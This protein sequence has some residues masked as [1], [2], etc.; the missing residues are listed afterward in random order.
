MRRGQFATPY[1]QVI[2]PQERSR[3]HEFPT[4]ENNGNR[5]LRDRS[6]L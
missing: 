1:L 2:F 6:L 5:Q 3:G 4:D